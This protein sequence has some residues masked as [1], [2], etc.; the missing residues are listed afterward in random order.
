MKDISKNQFVYL[1]VFTTYI[2]NLS[3]IP[4]FFGSNLVKSIVICLWGSMLFFIIINFWKKIDFSIIKYLIPLFLFD[5]LILIFQILT[6]NN[7]IESHFIYPIHLSALILIISYLIGQVTN[8]S[9]I[10]KIAN[11][12]VNSSLIVA[13]YVYII[14][15]RDKN[16]ISAGY[17]YGSKNSLSIILL[18]SII[19]I[20]IYWNERNIFINMSSSIFFFIIIFMMKSRATILALIISLFNFIFFIIKDKK[21][22]IFFIIFI[23]IIII[24][25]LFNEDLNHLI[26]NSVLLNN[27][28]KIDI[29]SIS[30]G[31]LDHLSDF[32]YLFKKNWIIGNGGIYLESFPLASLCSYGIIAGG[33]L[34]TFS[35]I[36]VII[37]FK[38]RKIKQYKTLNNIILLIS[39]VMLINS[40]FEELAP[41]GP[42]VKCYMLWLITG[43]YLGIIRRKEEKSFYE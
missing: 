13:I 33:V 5:I 31:R 19:L 14:F 16:W 36:P 43:L 29:N 23:F 11:S 34:I 7:Y 21:K 4:L 12:Y 20:F 2:S 26:I 15:F 42:G 18:I 10:K 32:L 8:T 30:S 6:G 39:I 27:K 9:I 22:K 28:E 1:L 3:Q 41:F 37:I 17:L 40:L 35:L 25:I 38:Y 24:L